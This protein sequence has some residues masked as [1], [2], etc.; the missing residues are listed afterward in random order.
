MFS[1]TRRR[2]RY[3]G[4]F[5]ELK[6]AEALGD[7]EYKEVYSLTQAAQASLRDKGPGGC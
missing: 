5:R 7:E 3:G 6:A 1:W 4:V 2:W